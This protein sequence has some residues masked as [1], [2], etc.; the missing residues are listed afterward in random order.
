M[1]RSRLKPSTV[2]M[3]GSGYICLNICVMFE[4]GI[5]VR[6]KKNQ[7]SGGVLALVCLGQHGG[8]HELGGGDKLSWGITCQPEST[9]DS[10]NA[11]WSTTCRLSNDEDKGRTPCSTTQ[12]QYT[13]WLKIYDER[14]VIA[15]VL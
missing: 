7:R 14:G 8:S 2:S 1:M 11:Y 13:V 3:V 9:L 15:F 5:W 12:L 10:W 6:H 4:T